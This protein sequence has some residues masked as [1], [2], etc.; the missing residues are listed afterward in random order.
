L[1]CTGS[2][3]K[4]AMDPHHLSLRLGDSALFSRSEFVFDVA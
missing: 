3:D 4:L 2:L 1:L